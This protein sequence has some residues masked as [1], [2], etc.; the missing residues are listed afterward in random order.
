MSSLKSKQQKDGYH[1]RELEGQVTTLTQKCTELKEKLLATANEN[2][3][4]QRNFITLTRKNQN[5]IDQC[6][7][8]MRT[9][10]ASNKHMLYLNKMAKTLTTAS[11][12]SSQFINTMKYAGVPR[13]PLD[14]KGASADAAPWVPNYQNF[15]HT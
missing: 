14:G 4:A 13:G 5:L 9:S 7:L 6:I 1:I 11:D 12:T 10:A 8:D 2:D 3:L 15:M